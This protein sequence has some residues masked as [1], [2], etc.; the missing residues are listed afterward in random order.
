M[1]CFS[2]RRNRSNC[3]LSVSEKNQMQGIW[4]LCVCVF[5]SH[6]S[7]VFFLLQMFLYSTP[8]PCKNKWAWEVLQ[9]KTH[10]LYFSSP[11]QKQIHNVFLPENK[12]KISRQLTNCRSKLSLFTPCLT[13][14]WLP[15]WS[16]NTLAVPWCLAAV[17][18]I[19][20]SW[21]SSCRTR[22]EQKASCRCLFGCRA[23]VL[24]PEY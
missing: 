17:G 14:H 16:Q 10:S 20:A 13:L 22:R 8:L 4:G 7:P 11:K 24:L 21:V 12:K 1:W 6:Q 19:A 15:V 3:L 9:A 5:A 18:F 23:A 2:L